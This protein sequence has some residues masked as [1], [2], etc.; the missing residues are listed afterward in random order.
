MNHMSAKLEFR[1]Q[2]LT[3]RRD[4]S[5]FL[6]L[7]SDLKWLQNRWRRHFWETTV[8]N[9]RKEGY[10]TLN[11][12][13]QILSNRCWSPSWRSQILFW[14]N[15]THIFVNILF[16]HRLEKYLNLRHVGAHRTRCTLDFHQ[17]SWLT[18]SSGLRF[19]LQFKV[20][21]FKPSN[22]SSSDSAI[23]CFMGV[24]R[25]KEN[26]RLVYREW[27]KKGQEQRDIGRSVILPGA[28]PGNSISVQRSLHFLAVSDPHQLK[29]TS[30]AASCS[31]SPAF[32]QSLSVCRVVS[33][34]QL[35]QHSVLVNTVTSCCRKQTS[36]SR[37]I[38]WS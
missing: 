24:V 20:W 4:R 32:F 10:I 22:R 31:T 25:L 1:A 13:F 11:I 30:S 9:K 5:L 26:K 34:E 27:G 19:L 3:A 17:P 28:L 36:H 23:S 6:F 7:V 2:K 29:K 14:L 12:R 33:G 18:F 8:G 21:F 38:S 35:I 16:D 37:R 15:P